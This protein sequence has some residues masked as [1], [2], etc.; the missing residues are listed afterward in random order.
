MSQ[1]IVKKIGMTILRPDADGWHSQ[2]K[3]SRLACTR[4]CD[5]IGADNYRLGAYGAQ[6]GSP[7]TIS[8]QPIKRDA[9]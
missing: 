1:S 3:S 8:S 4:R 6:S 2:R 7:I 9:A 5:Q